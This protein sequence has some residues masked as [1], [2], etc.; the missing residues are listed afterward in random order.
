MTIDEMKMNEIWKLIKYKWQTRNQKTFCYCPIC[1]N[2]LCS[3]NSYLFYRLCEE[4]GFEFYKCSRCG[5]QSKWNFD[6]A[7]APIL[8]ENQKLV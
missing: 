8:I 4:G 6:I 5:C 1:R 3:T 7:P 2:E